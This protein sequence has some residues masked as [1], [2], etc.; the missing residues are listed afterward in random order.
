MLAL[1]APLGAVE[2]PRYAPNRIILKVK[3]GVQAAKRASLYERIRA[4]RVSDLQFIGAVV[5]EL[6]GMSV[7]DALAIAR[8][9]PAVLYAEPDWEVH[10]YLVP[11]DPRF[12]ELWALRNTGQTGGTAGS[13]IR[14]TQAWDTFTGSTDVLIGVIDTGVDY[15]HP[16]LAANIWTNAA[17]AN[18]VEDVDDD[19]NGYVDDIHGYDFVNNDG[20]PMDDHFHGTH[21][22]GTIGAVGDNGFG[23]VGVNWRCKIAGIKFLDQGGGGS[24]SGALSAVQYAV[25]IGA[26]LTSNSWGGAFTSQALH[27]AVA[28]AGQH[29]QLFVCAAGNSGANLDSPASTAMPAE[30]DLPNVITVAA[31]DHSDQRASFSNYGATTVDVAA[32][33]VNVLSTVLQGGYAAFNGTSMAC[34][35]V[36][37]VCALLFGRYPGISYVTVRDL[38]L[39]YSDPLPQFEAITA[40]GGRLNALASLTL[41]PDTTSP[42]P[43]TDLAISDVGSTTMSV[44]WTATGD[45]GSSGTVRRLEVRYATFPID[46]QN[47]DSAQRA[48]APIPTVSGTQQHAEIAGVQYNTTYFVA[49]RATDEFSNSVVSNTATTTTLGVPQVSLTSLAAEQVVTGGRVQRTLRIANAGEG[50]LEF[51]MPSPELLYSPELTGKN[52]ALP[53]PAARAGTVPVIDAYGGPDA[54]GY[55]WSDSDEPD[56]PVFDWFEIRQTGTEFTF[57]GETSDPVPIGFDFPFY[58]D[59]HSEVQILWAGYLCFTPTYGAVITNTALPSGAQFAPNQMIAPYWDDLAPFPL[60]AGVWIGHLGYYQTVQTPDGPR[61]VATWSEIAHWETP[62]SSFTFQVV[63]S[64]SGEIRFQYQRMVAPL[65]TPTIG[66]QDRNRTRGIT[67]AYLESPVHDEM[68][69]RLFPARQ[70][71]RASP[72]L[73]SRLAAGESTDI[74]LTYDALALPAGTFDASVHVFSNEP[75]P[76]IVVPTTLTVTG[77]AHLVAT[78]DAFEF[79]PVYVGHPQIRDLHIE[80]LG[81]EPLVVTAVESSHPGV[82]VSP[83]TF[84]VEPDATQLVQVTAAPGSPSAIAGTI[85]LLSNDPDEPQRTLWFAGDATAAPI[86]AAIPDRLDARLGAGAAEGRVLRIANNGSAASVPLEYQVTTT[87]FE[88][89]AQAKGQARAAHAG[90]PDAFGYTWKDSREPG[91]PTYDWV[92]IAVPANRIENIQYDDRVVGSFPIGFPFTYY[93]RVYDRF[94][95]S[96]NGWISFAWAPPWRDNL[97][98]PA[99]GLNVPRALIA[100]FWMNLSLEAWVFETN[101]PAVYSYCDGSRRIVSFIGARAWATGP[102]FDYDFQ[103]ILDESGRIRFQYRY[104]SPPLTLAT[105]GIQNYERTVGLQIAHNEPF[106]ES[107]L[108]VEI[109]H[110]PQWLGLEPGAGAG[111]V[112]PGDFVDVVVTMNA[113]N[114]A[115]GDYVGRVRIESNDPETPR[116]DLPVNLQVRGDPTDAAADRPAQFALDLVGAN[117]ARGHATVRLAIPRRETVDVRV[118]NVRGALVRRILHAPRDPGHHDLRWDGRDEAGAHAASGLYFVRMQAGNVALSSRVVLLR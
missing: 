112:E 27:D 78:P 16:D 4:S 115:P 14:A 66:I 82:G 116:I 113:A 38:I 95:V 45:D 74:V 2:A 111:S 118:Y 42:G 19:G 25:A 101:G 59:R 7:E 51:T 70:W 37:G 114:L 103:V 107:E 109:Q 117:P 69:I 17:E 91:G 80:N 99:T 31:S 105:I 100:P 89:I 85:T 54:F 64:P 72:P 68:A 79:G 110:T 6:Q 94:W 21:C 106:V 10:A 26:D 62:R 46:A 104:V 23:V 28:V 13:D 83:S 41:P 102:E 35:H 8:S 50:R 75:Q 77:G 71:L 76:D 33:G 67:I 92:D 55:R 36:A 34:P 24:L 81:T 96:S 12:T 49:V 98:L 9:D 44:T 43:I 53:A 5:I 11:N 87:A 15:T 1:A 30:L 97:A 52:G 18:G 61:F 57:L 93:G 63:L 32:P 56:G 40:S 47:F 22:S 84:V 60:G 73:T 65:G 29:G 39:N 90:G 88:P 58:G 108:A 86:A 20:D 3:P 48:T